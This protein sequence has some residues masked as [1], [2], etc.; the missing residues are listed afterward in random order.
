VFEDWQ[1]IH[2]LLMVYA[3]RVD[4]ADFAGAAALFEH[5]TYSMRRGDATTTFTGAAEVVAGF[6]RTAIRYP[7]GTLR[8]KHLITNPIIELDGVV[9]TS[10]CYCTVL[11]GTDAFALQPI[12]AGRYLDRFE[13][14]GGAWRFSERVF[15]SH[16]IGDLSAHVPGHRG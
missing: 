5:A 7:D 13:K 11:Q 2:R 15:V 10:R 16:L 14:I 6:A 1:A 9:A 4:A 3:E 12:A 8:T